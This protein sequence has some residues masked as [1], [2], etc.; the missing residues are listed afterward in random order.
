V[1][2][3]ART[4]SVSRAGLIGTGVVLVVA[5]VCVRLGFWQLA[6]R[7]QRQARNAALVQRLTAAPLAL[8]RAPTDTTGLI[9]TPAT[10][11]G[12]YDHHHT[13]VLAGRSLRGIP[14]AH[15][16]TPVIFPGGG[17]AVLVNRGWMP[18][19]DGAT[20]KLDSLDHPLDAKVTGLLVP[21]PS[22]QRRGA[23]VNTD[24]SFRRVWFTVDAKALRAQFPYAVS[25][26]QLQALPGPDAPQFPIRLP[27]PELDEGPHLG[28]AIQWFS[29]ALI[30][31]VGWVTL[32]LRKGELRHVDTKPNA[33]DS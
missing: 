26:I 15:V 27:R 29:F 20:V 19:A 2:T 5:L 14:G 32:M 17:S 1:Q 10:V 25:P 33:E 23:T 9:F 4:L 31:L 11:E 28:Y 22:A 24:S 7:E 30:F 13:I 6:R 12:R 18:A 8:Q 3:A 16:L 21:F